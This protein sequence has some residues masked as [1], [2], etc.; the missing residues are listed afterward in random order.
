ML[1]AYQ[2]AD[3]WRVKPDTFRA[4]AGNDAMPEV[5]S[6]NEIKTHKPGRLSRFT[7]YLW[8][9][10]APIK[11]TFQSLLIETSKSCRHLPVTERRT[12]L[13]MPDVDTMT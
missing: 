13:T 7:A 5:D 1:D 10:T 4:S 6:E 12:E 11:A 3:Q 9:P 8:T 2:Q